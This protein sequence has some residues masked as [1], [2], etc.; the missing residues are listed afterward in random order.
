MPSTSVFRFSELIH[1]A[2]LVRSMDVRCSHADMLIRPI[3][4][5]IYMGRHVGIM[6]HVNRK[7]R[8]AESNTGIPGELSYIIYEVPTPSQGMLLTVFSV[9]KHPI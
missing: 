6:N 8:I 9:Y 3:D 5:S 1:E 4:L 2:L 7:E